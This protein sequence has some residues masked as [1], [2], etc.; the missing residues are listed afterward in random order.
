MHMLV[1]T[2]LSTL[3][4]TLMKVLLDMGMRMITGPFLEEMIVWALKK[5][6]ASTKTNIDDEIVDM[7]VKALE[8]NKAK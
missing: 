3:G 4:G 5:A 8:E 1:T 7:V 6:S 2:L